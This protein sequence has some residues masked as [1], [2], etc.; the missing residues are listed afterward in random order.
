MQKLTTYLQSIQAIIN[1][2]ELERL[3]GCPAKT[4]HNAVAGHQPLPQKWAGPILRVLCQHF[5]NVVIDGWTITPDP[6]V[7]TIFFL[8]RP[9]PDQEAQSLEVEDEKGNCHYEYFMPQYRDVCDVPDL[10]SM[11]L[12]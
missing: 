5:G 12:S 7:P 2:S 6:E 11:Y 10:I 1:L 8:A 3:A 4:I 9:I